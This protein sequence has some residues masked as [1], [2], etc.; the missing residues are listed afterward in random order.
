MSRKSRKG[1]KNLAKLSIPTKLPQSTKFQPKKV[2]Y[3]VTLVVGVMTA[4]TLNFPKILE[5][6]R[7]IPVEY[8]KTKSD[9][10]IWKNN[11]SQWEG[12][13]VP[14]PEGY[15]D[16]L[17]T[18]NV[19][20]EVVIWANKGE[21]SGTIATPFI[22]KEYS[23][24]KYAQLKGKVNF[25]NSNKADMEVWDYIGGKRTLLGKLKFIKKDE[26]IINIKTMD[27][28]PL[29]FKEVNLGKDPN[30]HGDDLIPNYDFCSKLNYIE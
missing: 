10:M 1:N 20:S 4:I 19:K 16:L 28:N 11:D 2:W 24:I 13:Y 12:K 5:S 29:F 26:I 18:S 8:Q 30:I 21:I 6:L 9:F 25:L 27:E 7:V 23:F 14:N 15:L 22:C 17:E 3:G